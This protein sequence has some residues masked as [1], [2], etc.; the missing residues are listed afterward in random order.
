MDKQTVS[1]Q[2]VLEFA[3]NDDLIVLENKTY[4][5]PLIIKSSITLKGPGRIYFGQHQLLVSEGADV[6]FEEIQFEVGD[7]QADA[8]LLFSNSQVTFKKCSI[9][10][11]TNGRGLY[12][13]L[14]AENTNLTFDE[15]RIEAHSN[16]IKALN[17]QTVMIS[18][19]HIK[20]HN[21][22]IG[23]EGHQVSEF[24][25]DNNRFYSAVD[26]LRLSKVGNVSLINNHFIQLESDLYTHSKWIEIEG[27]ERGEFTLIEN[28][29]F[30]LNKR[31]A[32]NVKN[33]LVPSR[34]LIIKDTKVKYEK[35]TSLLIDISYHQGQVTL[36]NN[37]FGTAK[38]STKQ[39]SEI[40]LEKN[41]FYTYVGKD[42]KILNALE[43]NIKQ[44]LGLSNSHYV[45]LLRNTFT[46]E[47]SDK[48]AIHLQGIN[49]LILEKNKI[50]SAEHGIS[51]LNAGDNLEVKLIGNEFL[52]CRSRAVN[53]S[54]SMQKKHLKT[55]VTFEG[56]IFS[57]NDRGIYID[58][59]NLKSCLIKENY[60]ADNNG[61][62]T[63]FGGKSTSEIKLDGNY[64]SDDMQLIE[65]RGTQLLTLMNNTLSDSKLNLRGSDEILIKGNKMIKHNYSGKSFHN[66]VSIRAGG[67]LT[68]TRNKL[69]LGK[70]RQE[71]KEV[72]DYLN[73][74]AYERTP[75]LHIGGNMP[76][77]ESRFEHQYKIDYD[78][79]CPDETLLSRLKYHGD[80][81]NLGD[82]NIDE[83]LHKDFV[84]LRQT[85][86]KLNQDIQ[87]SM[88]KHYIEDILEKFTMDIFKERDTND[89]YRFIVATNE[90]VEM[91]KLF[92]SIDENISEETEVKMK[93]ILDSYMLSMTN[94][95]NRPAEEEEEKLNA[96]MKLL[97]QLI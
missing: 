40:Q 37:D 11:E 75:S 61:A 5:E 44:Y 52:N 88:M 56:N 76:L 34:A 82:D 58:D 87:S 73:I 25:F 29:E 7:G 72:S 94:Y 12:A 32:I 81:R 59:R 22:Q 3:Q 48:E 47:H 71:K 27:M 16:V 31:A 35:D 66:E 62:V 46:N 30:E 60:F 45:A 43:N 84:K 1:L 83:M 36:E 28:N 90:T 69:L 55:E 15:C 50:S 23:I 4:E 26:G 51:F 91:I 89:A 8:N 24:V 95:L 13:T 33:N 64:F 14:W 77:S 80:K 19:T 53:F 54:S 92:L 70:P 17:A 10:S 6:V 57:S 97:E 68:V 63:V 65:M 41:S 96:Q 9:S 78:L 85:L 20:C 49:K 86:E 39:C 21:G 18:N 74:T 38:V 79:K 93:G 2:K 42:F 67:N